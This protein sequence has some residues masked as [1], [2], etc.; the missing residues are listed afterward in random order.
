[1]LVVQPTFVT[2]GI[3][4]GPAKRD[5]HKAQDPVHIANGMH[6]PIEVE[7]EIG[8]S[9]ATGA[10]LTPSI[11]GD[12]TDNPKEMTQSKNATTY[13]DPKVGQSMEHLCG[14]TASQRKLEFT[15]QPGPPIQEKNLG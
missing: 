2:V 14:T 11:V 12:F 1:M 15:Q 7:N 10:M 13:I 6:R 3:A 5:K 4:R 9:G 8:G